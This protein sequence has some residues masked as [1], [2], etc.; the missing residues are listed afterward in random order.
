LVSSSRSGSGNRNE[1][2]FVDFRLCRGKDIAKE[3][4]H[5]PSEKK[6][7]GDSKE[8]TSSLAGFSLS[9][10]LSRERESES[11][12]KRKNK[13]IVGWLFSFAGFSALYEAH[14]LKNK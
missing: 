1:N 10:S 12:P 8:D 13:L 6:R 4:N 14:L 3:T 5:P 9:L 11:P 7:R 2:P